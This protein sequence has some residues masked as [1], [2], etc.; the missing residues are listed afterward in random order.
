MAFVRP[1]DVSAAEEPEILSAGRGPRQILHM[2][3][4]QSSR[5]KLCCFAVSSFNGDDATYEDDRLCLL[6]RTKVTSF[7]EVTACALVQRPGR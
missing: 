4:Q 2:Q 1:G 7:E 6:A 5:S 3:L